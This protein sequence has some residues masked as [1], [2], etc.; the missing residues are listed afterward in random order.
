MDETLLFMIRH[1]P[2][3]KD[4]LDSLIQDERNSFEKILLDSWC[5]IA[6]KF[7]LNTKTIL[8]KI[9]ISVL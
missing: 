3:I 6:Q 8:K 2:F 1:F 4:F 5:F 7:E 9:S